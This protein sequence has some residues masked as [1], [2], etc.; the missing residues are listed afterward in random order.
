MTLTK[1]AALNTKAKLARKI[2]ELRENEE[3]FSK[4]LQELSHRWLSIW[5]FYRPSHVYSE[6]YIRWPKELWK[7][8][9]E[10]F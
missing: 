6:S 8:H 4:P 2:E 3:T 10:I 9:Q 7:E 5:W 1:R